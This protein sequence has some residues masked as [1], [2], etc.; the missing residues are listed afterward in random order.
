MRIFFLGCVLAS[1][2]SAAVAGVVP[3]VIVAPEPASLGKVVLLPDADHT[4]STSPDRVKGRALAAKAVDQLLRSKTAKA[5]NGTEI[6]VFNAFPNPIQS[7]QPSDRPLLSGCKAQPADDLSDRDMDGV[8]Y[9]LVRLDCPVNSNPS[10]I[11]VAVGE[12]QG[13]VST[14]ILNAGFVPVRTR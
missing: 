8:L 10:K 9:Y 3:G 1:L 4:N 5:A 13:T 14:L 11:Y 6:Y 7:F 2:T 12:R